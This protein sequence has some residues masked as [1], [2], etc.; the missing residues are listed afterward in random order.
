MQYLLGIDIGTSACKAA[1]FDE[2]GAVTAQRSGEYPVLRPKPGWAEQ[3]PDDWWAAVCGILREMLADSG[4]PPSSIAGIGVDGQSWAAIPVGRDGSVLANT[5]I[6]FDTRSR[7][8]CDRLREEVGEETL[9]DLCGNPLQP[10]YSLPKI[11]WFAEHAPQVYRDAAQFLQ[12]N[13]FIVYRLTGVCSQDRSQGYGLHCYNMRTSAWDEDTCRRMGLDPGKLPPLF[14]CHAIVGTVTRQ[15]ASLTGLAEGTPVAAGGLD[16]ACGA[17]G[18]GVLHAGET[19]E[20]GGQAGGMSICIEHYHADPRLILSHHVVP[21]RWLLQGGS[22]GGG[23]VMR[24]LEEELG[25]LERQ[26]AAEHGTSA[27]AELDRTA[28][29][30]PAGCEGVV[31][32]PYL[33]GERSPIWN[34]AAKGVW[35]GL[36]YT[37]TRAHLI[38]A[39]MEGA[40][41]ALR[42]NLET[43]EDC[44]VQ[45]QVL[46]AMGGAANS[47][48]WTQM[49]ADVTGKRIVVPSS[50]TATTWGAAM[51]AGVGVGLFPSFEE[52]VSRSVHVRRE[53]L[54]DPAMRE[55]YQKSYQIYRA[56]YPALQPVMDQNEKGMEQR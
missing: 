25:A 48:L 12:A 28:A 39:G 1:L 32:L 44:G 15:A 19:Q 27:F 6:W 54:P 26:R 9:F 53:Y 16:A 18:V 47:R 30:V 42:H 40:A 22:V 33:A 49:K 41:F 4:I 35:Y 8:V 11:L 23:G 46:R 34:E 52:A 17:L 43:A 13:S 2:T 10:G 3:A 7:P 31:F 21:G 5:P 24:W 56:L 51:L 50:D 37:K 14:D 55:A 29:S 20:Q 36:D 38:R 45:A